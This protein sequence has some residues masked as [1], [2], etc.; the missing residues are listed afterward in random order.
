[1]RA[2]PSI[3]LLEALRNGLNTFSLMLLTPEGVILYANQIAA[4][5]FPG[6]SSTSLPGKSIFGL[7]PDAWARERV[8]YFERVVRER[9]PLLV[10]EIIEGVRL[11]ARLQAIETS[12]SGESIPVILMTIEPILADN[13]YWLADRAEQNNVVMADTIDL[14]HLN[15]LSDREI[16]VLALMGQGYRQK[17]IAKTLCRSVSTIN[18]HRESMGTKLNITDRAKLIRLANLA[19]LQVDDAQRRRMPLNPEADLHNHRA[20]HHTVI[21]NRDHPRSDH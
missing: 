15:I 14:G 1:M 13:F 8:G 4:N 12:V 19:V 11:C 21:D 3:K 2:I 5:G 20:G 16:E 10:I 6:E 17:D 7:T 9:R 18:R